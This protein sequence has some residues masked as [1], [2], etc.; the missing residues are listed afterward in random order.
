[1]SKGLP[2][3]EKQQLISEY[4]IHEKD[5]GSP[6]VQIA[7]LMKR[8]AKL[9]EHVK[10]HKADHHTTLG[11]QKMNAKQRRLLNYLKGEDFDR[12]KALAE[13]LKIRR[14]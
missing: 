10:I 9:T 5:S 11:L 13:R 12:Y 8:V 2:A 4:R 14:R 3:E 7:V 1:M 6:E